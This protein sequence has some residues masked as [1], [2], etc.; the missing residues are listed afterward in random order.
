MQ[1]YA[2]N[3]SEPCDIVPY[4]NDAN[5]L[6]ETGLGDRPAKDE[7]IH[8]A[9]CT[10][11]VSGGHTFYIDKVR[12]RQ[13]PVD[14]KTSTNFR[15]VVAIPRAF[16]PYMTAEHSGALPSTSSLY[17]VVA[18]AFNNTKSRDYQHLSIASME[19]HFNP[20]LYLQWLH[21]Y[22]TKDHTKRRIVIA[23]HG[24]RETN[25]DIILKANFSMKKI[26]QNTGNMGWFGKGR[27]AT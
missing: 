16:V 26:G 20:E 1:W 27:L 18:G 17:K 21:K 9:V 15:H 13:Y 24:T 5:K 19:Y 14:F 2:V 3:P 6:I 22:E 7:L 23:F 10:T 25:V 4:D 11:V 12:K 8:G